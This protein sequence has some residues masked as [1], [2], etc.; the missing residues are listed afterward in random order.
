MD[1]HTHPKSLPPTSKPAPDSFATDKQTTVTR[2]FRSGTV[3]DMQTRERA[4]EIDR[5]EQERLAKEG[6]V[7]GMD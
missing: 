7:A 2:E 6:P 3:A 4:K 5:R 1:K